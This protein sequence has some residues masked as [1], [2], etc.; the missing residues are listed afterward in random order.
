MA[1]SGR[2]SSV[3]CR[4]LGQVTRVKVRRAVLGDAAAIAQVHT[5]GWRQGFVGLLPAKYLAARVVET[6]EW[7]ARLAD[8]EPHA[9]FVAQSGS[10]TVDG[11]VSGFAAVGAALS[12]APADGTTG[13]LYAI[14]VLAEVWGT[15]VGYALHT[16]A[17]NALRAAGFD[18]AVLWH[19]QGNTRTLSFYQRQGWQETATMQVEDLGGAKAWQR[20]LR[21]PLS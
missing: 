3:G 6:T 12:P 11:P 2:T 15:G 17:M 16:T 8:P 7:S 9:V 5:L 13:Q 4:I 19:L 21:L 10:G 14:Y 20:L 18:E 1:L